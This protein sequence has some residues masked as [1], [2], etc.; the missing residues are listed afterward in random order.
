MYE[1]KA[2]RRDRFLPEFLFQARY[3]RTS[4]ETSAIRSDS[5]AASSAMSSV[6]A[7][8]TKRSIPW[9][10]PGYMVGMGAPRS[11]RRK[12][13]F[14]ALVRRCQNAIRYRH[15]PDPTIDRASRVRSDS[16]QSPHALVSTGVSGDGLQC[17]VCREHGG[18]PSNAD[19]KSSIP[20][21]N[22]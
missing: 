13:G 11:S 2:T 19:R 14:D 1:I 4:E 18:D 8:V 21:R 12:S 10:S 5:E 22:S 20:G 3:R 17:R 9:Q 6:R 7:V 15:D 16:P